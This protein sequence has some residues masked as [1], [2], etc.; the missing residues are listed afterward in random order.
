MSKCFALFLMRCKRVFPSRTAISVLSALSSQLSAPS[1]A[2]AVQRS[3]LR[4][5]MH[6]MF[7]PCWQPLPFCVP[8]P[9]AFSGSSFVQRFPGP[10]PPRAGGS[11]RI[12][13]RRRRP[14]CRRAPHSRGIRRSRVR[15]VRSDGAGP[16]AKAR[17]SRARARGGGAGGGSGGGSHVRLRCS[18][19]LSA[20]LLTQ[21]TVRCPRLSS[22]IL[23]VSPACELL[24]HLS[25]KVRI[26]V[27]VVDPR[28][29]FHLGRLHPRAEAVRY[30][31]RGPPFEVVLRLD[32]GAPPPLLIFPSR[33]VRQ[34][35]F[36]ARN[37]DRFATTVGDARVIGVPRA[38]AVRGKREQLL[39]LHRT[40]LLTPVLVLVTHPLPFDEDSL[41]SQSLLRLSGRLRWSALLVSLYK[42]CASRCRHSAS[43]EAR[44]R[45]R[46]ASL[47][48]AL[49]RNPALELPLRFIRRL[50]HS[51]H[52]LCSLL[53]L[54]C[55]HRLLGRF[56]QRRLRHQIP[57]PVSCSSVIRRRRRR[58]GGV[59][60]AAAAAA[61]LNKRWQGASSRRGVACKR[62]R[63]R[64]LRRGSSRG[65]PMRG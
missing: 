63:R 17:G 65:H 19:R 28:L 50:L 62:R 12:H 35:L 8:P 36:G 51:S 49:L 16:A 45:R 32:R 15:G 59:A 3:P 2:C 43:S 22:L 5:H 34:I 14:H 23:L 42:T 46:F 31:N 64:R 41:A 60:A 53:R 13:R 37:V 7:T 54:Y 39:P 56:A 4:C 30:R 10:T 48:Q 57:A 40:V 25:L 55:V 38:E 61:L 33:R 11:G 44:M 9:P 29:F 27:S 47:V 21:A 20:L 24:L 1:L 58:R 6:T 52:L 26:E 18:R